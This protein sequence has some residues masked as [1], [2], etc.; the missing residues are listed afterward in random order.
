MGATELADYIRLLIHV[1]KKMC[2][3]FLHIPTRC[4]N[5]G[6][7]NLYAHMETMYSVQASLHSAYRKV[8]SCAL[9]LRSLS[10]NLTDNETCS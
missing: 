4:L 1:A 3:Y 9:S 7:V 6:S 8:T 5:V 10:P 2:H